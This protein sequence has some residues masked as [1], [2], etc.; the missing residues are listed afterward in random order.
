MPSLKS[1]ELKL[2]DQLFIDLILALCEGL[3]RVV[4]R[5]IGSY[6]AGG[7]YFLDFGELGWT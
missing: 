5:K 2:I 7:K 4:K 6:A 3:E 1:R